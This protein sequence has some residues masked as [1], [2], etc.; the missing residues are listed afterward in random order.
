MLLE[1]LS[2]FR[3]L[4]L[5]QVTSYELGCSVF[6]CPTHPDTIP[7]QL[8]KSC[9]TPDW[10]YCFVT[11][12]LEK[13]PSFSRMLERC[14]GW[15]VILS[16]DPWFTSFEK[17]IFLVCSLRKTQFVSSMWFQIE[18][19]ALLINGSISRTGRQIQPGPRE[20]S[21]DFYLVSNLGNQFC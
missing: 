15:S 21:C 9:Y 18:I 6:L 2:S 14:K 12:S 11:F 16:Y 8:P 10:L 3:N 20:S 19:A 13:F 4:A 5:W 7:I 17:S 1:R